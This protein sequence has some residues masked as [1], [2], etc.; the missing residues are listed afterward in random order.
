MTY[1][2][3]IAVS[4]F[5]RTVVGLALSLI[6]GTCAMFVIRTL[7]A[8]AG[9]DWS[10]LVFTFFWFSAI[11]VGGGLGGFIPWVNLE[12]SQE[13]RKILLISLGVVL[14]AAL[15]GAWGG[16]YYKVVLTD[17]LTPWTGRA[18]TSTVIFGAAVAANLV[19]VP[20]GL[21]WR[22]RRGW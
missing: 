21:Y 4:L 17:S 9:G 20:I 14:L 10:S 3:Y 5:I 22:S 7:F 11:G 6:L 13:S 2:W 8:V 12:S 16:Y 18:V 1:S 19:A 15:G